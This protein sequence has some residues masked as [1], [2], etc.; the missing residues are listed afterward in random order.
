[1]SETTNQSPRSTLQEA[2]GLP[3]ATAPTKELRHGA[4]LGAPRSWRWQ[5]GGT[6]ALVAVPLA[7]MLSWRSV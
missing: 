4:S 1:V 2:R 7:E 5:S 6:V 3:A